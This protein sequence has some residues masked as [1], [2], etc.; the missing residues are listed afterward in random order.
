MLHLKEHVPELTI[1]HP[2]L[3]SFLT[4]SLKLSWKLATC[5]P[6]MIVTCDEK[7]YDGNIHSRISFKKEVPDNHT[8]KYHSPTLYT[9]YTGLVQAKGQVEIISDSVSETNQPIQSTTGPGTIVK[10]NG[11]FIIPNID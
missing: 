5:V 6:P 9:N 2:Q 4:E 3:D 10:I 11:A 8:L 1:K 7:H